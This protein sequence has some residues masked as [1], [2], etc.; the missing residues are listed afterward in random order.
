[1]KFDIISYAHIQLRFAED[2]DF[3][4]NE[5]IEAGMFSEEGSL[6]FRVTGILKEKTILPLEL[7]ID[8]PNDETTYSCGL[9]RLLEEKKKNNS[10]IKAWDI[11]KDIIKK[12]VWDELSKEDFYENRLDPIVETI[13]SSLRDEQV[14]CH[15]SD[16]KVHISVGTAG[17][18]EIEPIQQS[19]RDTIEYLLSRMLIRIFEPIEF[20]PKASYDDMFKYVEKAG[21]DFDERSDVIAVSIES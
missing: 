12:E 2:E 20:D 19:Q 6:L 13:I 9:E 17:A 21:Y 3:Y 7:Y 5:F 11:M 4:D 16:G 15:T 18:I 1:M 10:K 8:R 14:K